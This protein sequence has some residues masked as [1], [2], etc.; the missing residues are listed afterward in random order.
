MIGCLERTGGSAEIVAMGDN[1]LAYFFSLFE[2]GIG[3]E[4]PRANHHGSLPRKALTEDI[5]SEPAD[6][7]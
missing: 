4:S 6:P 2:Q 5:N 1:A 7:Y 3:G